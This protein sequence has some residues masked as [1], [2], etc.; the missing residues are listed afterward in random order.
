MRRSKQY[1]ALDA[2]RMI[3]VVFLRLNF[4]FFERRIPLLLRVVVLDIYQHLVLQLLH[5]ALMLGSSKNIVI[6]LLL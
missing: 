3:L 2:T 1:R 4:Q 5:L 6:S